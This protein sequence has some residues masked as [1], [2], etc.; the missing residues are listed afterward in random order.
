M[1]SMT[2]PDKFDVIVVGGGHAGCESALAAARMGQ[3]CLLVTIN[4]DHIAALSCNPAV[5]GLAKGHLVREI[6]AMGGQMG[7]AAD[8]AGIQFRLLNRS[9]GAAVW[10]SRAQVDMDLYPKYMRNVCLNQE[11]L[12]LLDSKARGLIIE[13]G[14][15]AGVTTDRG[16][17]IAGRSV[18]LTTGTFLRGLIHV[19]LRN[20]PAGRMGDPS[21]EAL[22]AQ[23]KDLGLNL[24]RLKTGTCPRLDARTVDLGSLETQPGDAE[25][26]MFSFLSQKPKLPQMPCWVTAT[27]AKTH[28]II[29]DHL[30]QSPLYA[31]VITGVG[32]RYCPSIEDKVVRFPERGGHQVFLEPQGL[33]NGLLYPNG[34]PT[35]LPLEAQEG[36]VHSLPGCEN[37]FIVRPG[38]AIEY[39]YSDPLDLKPTFESKIVPGLYLAGQ[40]NGTSGYEE[41]AAQGLW[42]GVNA[43]LA[44][45]GEDPLVLDRSQAYMAVLADDLVTKGTGEPYRMFT[46]RAEYRLSLREDNADVRLSRIGRD[47]GLVDDTRWAVFSAK[48]A[49]L[50]K[51][52]EL[53]REVRINPTKDTLDALERLGTG[54]LTKPLSAAEVLRR[55]GMDLAKLA[56]LHPALEPLKD[57]PADA[58]MQIEIETHYAGYVEQERQRVEQ[59]KAKESVVL[60]MGMDY[61]AIAGLSREVVEKLSRI[62]PANLGQAGRISGVTPAA[63]TLIS[64]HVGR[65]RPTN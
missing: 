42:A 31:G 16:H 38:Y 47:I 55:P 32:A 43:V 65:M 14:R 19:G 51:A 40:I 22:S 53:L 24:G 33:E 48:L 26:R 17:R 8:A 4:L 61:S 9:K 11:S 45:R 28:E 20:W 49:A 25:P 1:S 52:A 54:S 5:G 62:R 3:K 56:T 41:A 63:L 13:N 39:D 59:F 27:N 10:S 21:A 46:S 30:D 57:L 7:L 37:A 50:E 18:V 29:R 35:S 2:P 60:P 34:I 23:L 6:D 36:M 12:W 44:L 64:L 58:A 15:A